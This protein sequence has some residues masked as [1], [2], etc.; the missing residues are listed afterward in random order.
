MLGV[1]RD[2]FDDGLASIELPGG[3]LGRFTGVFL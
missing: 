2:V 3:L 1:V